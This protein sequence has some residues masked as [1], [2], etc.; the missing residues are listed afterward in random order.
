MAKDELVAAD[1]KNREPL[2][3]AGFI[4]QSEIYGGINGFWD[5]GP[6]GVELKKNL[7]DFWWRRN[8]RERDDMEGMDG[9]SRLMNRA[10][11]KASGHEETFSDPMVDCRSCK[12]RHRADQL[13]GEGGHE[14]LSELRK[15]GF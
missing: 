6:L 13:P 9:A 12:A 1:G 15:P 14:V 7:K 4:F 3:E 2:Q 11:W 8:V 10:V 5:Y